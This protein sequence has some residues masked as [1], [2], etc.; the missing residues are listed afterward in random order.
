MPPKREQP[1]DVAV[2]VIN[3]HT[4]LPYFEV[5][6]V[7]EIVGKFFSVKYFKSNSDEVILEN[8]NILQ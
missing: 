4:D 6:Q 5:R 1:L 8:M 2:R 7:N 3:T